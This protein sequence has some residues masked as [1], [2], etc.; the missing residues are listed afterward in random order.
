[1]QPAA[2]LRKSLSVL[3]TIALLSAL[4]LPA[5][6]SEASE[7]T[8]PPE[9]AATEA[10]VPETAA[11]P[12]DE[13]ALEATLPAE[14]TET[15]P[16]E[17][18]SAGLTAA[19]SA[20]SFASP[21]SLYFGLL[22]AHTNI[23]DGLGSIEEAFAHAA[24]VPGLD[25][26]AVTDHSNSFDNADAGALTLEGS[27]ISGEWAAGKAAAAAVTNDAFL[28]IF[29]YEM[30]WPEIRQLGHITT[31]CTPGWISRDQEGF[32][33]DASAL[34]HYLEA[35]ASVPGSVS[36]F[37]H[38]GKLFGD[39]DRFGHWQP[40]FDD[41]VQLL[42]TLGEGSIASYIQALDQFW[43]VAPTAT[44][45]S[46]NGNWG[47]ENDLRT[48]VLADAL[49]EESLFQAIRARRVYATE[50][51][52]LHLHYTLNGHCMGSVLS[53]ADSPE[54]TLSLY[55]PTDPAGCRVEVIA[56]GGI[57][58]VSRELG[59]TDGPLTFP[60]PGGYRWYF[61]KIIQPDG[62]IAVTAPVWVEGFENMG[63]S[64]FTA[65]AQ[66]PVQG[67]PL[68]LELT[69]YNGEAIEFT[70]SFLAFYAGDVLI[71]RADSPDPV[72]PG[73]SL[74]HRFS[75][76][77]P[78]AGTVRLRAVASGTVLGRERVFE[79]SLSLRF[80][81]GQTVTGALMDGSH[82]STEP[83]TLNQLKALLQEAGLDVT[84]F[85]G[86]MPQGGT[87]LIL[88]PMKT[89]PD[90]G[91]REDL[92][93]FLES[94]GSILLWDDGPQGN[95]LLEALGVSLR[96]GSDPVPAGSAELF[97]TDSP[98][99]A[100]LVAGQFFSCPEGCALDPGSGTWL[101]KDEAGTVRLACE[102]TA[103]GGTVF[104]AGSPFLL[105][106]QLLPAENRW[107]LP[108]ANRT[109]LQTILDIG[110]E[111]PEQMSI[112]EVRDAAEG[113][114]YR[115]KGYV[116]AGTANPHTIF[117]DTI[118]L[119]DD[120]GGI[121]VRG[122]SVA[123]IQI[124]APMEVIGTLGTENG[125]PVL[126]YADHR[127]LQEPYHRYTPKPTSC[128]TAMHYETH[129]GKLMQVEGT[130]TALTLTKDRK[131]ISRLELR[132]IRGGS[133]IIEIEDTVGSGT[134]GL[135]RL[136]RT[137]KK[138][139]TVQAMGL[140]HINE[141]GETVLRVRNCDEVVCIPPEADPTNPKT[142]DRRWWF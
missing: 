94:G 100:G 121:A 115:I 109:F 36:Q 134:D 7:E 97:N 3:L 5:A 89:E 28:G 51:R 139:C 128:K 142:A 27:S 88:P 95:V 46:H 63:I 18:E 103:W 101:V 41:A 82:G 123:D 91:F 113:G 78:D 24:A 98:W 53:S 120:T 118:Y 71:H 21:Y 104:A 138:G 37:C 107:E 76:T 136:A 33:D 85:T 39:F 122:F 38:P 69:L 16:S 99:C 59:E 15:E 126:H 13:T 11:V 108:R 74:S 137:I 112:R 43:H 66:T 22:H 93:H 61:L 29:G 47:S 84:V 86:P 30:T 32:A 19:S 60:V 50:D 67:Q 8:L 56:E 79:E 140:L 132:D 17:P 35:L 45:N 23:S 135:N 12:A 110:T 119:Q 31:Y 62:D 124:G 9:T 2:R 57:T 96:F 52:D 14:S 92:R 42:E 117:P 4:L 133:A 87:L 90:R 106:S 54:I 20:V 125:N 70:L 130:V 65:D 49:T 48:V 80:R 127:L 68:E 40:E 114:L 81:S 6:A 131:G 1:M 72:P 34:E 116:T 44:Q 105:D 75:Y 102:Q 10:S 73:N 58:A 141:A 25:F 83:E 77:H 64:S 111:V 26:F 55:D 129:G